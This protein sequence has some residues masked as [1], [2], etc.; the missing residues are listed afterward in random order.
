MML[1]GYNDN[2]K[3]YKLVDVKTN[4]TCLSCD[5]VVDESAGL[6]QKKS[7]LKSEMKVAENEEDMAGKR[8]NG[9]GK[10]TRGRDHLST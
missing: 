1:T 4:T 8:F 10:S 2:H 7:D 6:F 9:W 3:A 5:V